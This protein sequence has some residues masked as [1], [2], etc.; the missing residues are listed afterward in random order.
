LSEIMGGDRSNSFSKNVPPPSGLLSN[1]IQH[2]KSTNPSP[3][4]PVAPSVTSSGTATYPP[5]TVPRADSCIKST[6]SSIQTHKS[7]YGPV[8]EARGTSA[9]HVARPGSHLSTLSGPLERSPVHDPV[10]VPHATHPMPPPGMAYGQPQYPPRRDE[11]HQQ[12]S[13]GPIYQPSVMHNAPAANLPA[14]KSENGDYSPMQRHD[15][16][17]DTVKRHLDSQH[18]EYALNEVS[19]ARSSHQ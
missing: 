14:W 8:D 11:S 5:Y 18:L 12:P 17:K 3:A 15:G 10:Q 13:L 7:A 6:F 4:S 2:S 19:V 16:H 9:V 1:Q